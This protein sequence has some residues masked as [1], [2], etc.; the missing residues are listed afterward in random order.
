MR[1]AKLKS[2]SILRCSADTKTTVVQHKLYQGGRILEM[3]VSAMVGDGL[4][5]ARCPKSKRMMG[6][7]RKKKGR[8][9]PSPTRK[10]LLYSTF[11]LTMC[12]WY[13]VLLYYLLF[14][15][16]YFILRCLMLPLPYSACHFIALQSR[17]AVFPIEDGPEKRKYIMYTR[18]S[19]TMAG[20]LKN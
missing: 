4:G 1:E 15:V 9:K 2:K 5:D 17:R 10:K 20:T 19:T 18:Y 16:V 8:A 3:L 6:K 7:G 13:N 12:S 14:P 11:S